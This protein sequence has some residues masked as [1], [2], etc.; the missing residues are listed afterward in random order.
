MIAAI[1]LLAGCGA[2]KTW[3]NVGGSHS[4]VTR[5]ATLSG[6][7]VKVA[8]TILDMEPAPSVSAG[9]SEIEQSQAQDKAS[10]LVTVYLVEVDPVLSLN[11]APLLMIS[12]PVAGRTYTSKVVTLPAGS[13]EVV[14]GDSGVQ[15]VIWGVR[16]FEKK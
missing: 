9:A 4:G 14:A 5:Y 16:V 12:K 3:Q 15:P 13:Y 2:E 10:H 11:S 7:E 1:L 6:G 8:C